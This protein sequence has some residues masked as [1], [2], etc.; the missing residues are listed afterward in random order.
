MGR[1]ASR[2]NTKQRADHLMFGVKAALAS[3]DSAA[4]KLH[5]RHVQDRTVVKRI[6][7]GATPLMFPCQFNVSELVSLAVPIGDLTQV[8]GLTTSHTRHLSAHPD[9]PQEGIVLGTSTLRG[10][11]RPVALAPADFTKHLH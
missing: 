5:V 4:N 2:A 3:T 11:E 6:E 8:A 10:T 7:R 1:I 9:I